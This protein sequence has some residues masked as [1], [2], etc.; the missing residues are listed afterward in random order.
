[1]YT[2]PNFR[3]RSFFLKMILAVIVLMNGFQ[4]GYAQSVHQ[5]RVIH[6]NPV[7]ML[8]VGPGDT[9]RMLGFT[10]SSALDMEYGLLPFFQESF[11]L[12]SPDDHVSFV[13]IE[14]PV[15]HHATQLTCWRCGRY[16]AC[17]AV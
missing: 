7:Q 3:V 15:L 12:N 13:A 8:A 14:N 2:I 10:G 11:R 16:A 4:A 9:L 5:H 1:M 17:V 6:W